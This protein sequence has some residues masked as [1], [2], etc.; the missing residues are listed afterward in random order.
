MSLYLSEA[1]AAAL[2]GTKAA[3][4]SKYGAK[5]AIVDGIRFDSQA[6][7]ARYSTLIV[8]QRAGRIH[9]LELQ[10]VFE[11]HALSGA[12]VCRYRGDFA[13]LDVETG[14]RVCEDVKGV[15]TPLYR[16]KAKFVFEEYGVTIREIRA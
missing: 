7:A 12:T 8:L 6:E 13:Y 10:P 14:L 3:K 4:R 5:P 9:E 15:R 1:D 16:L 11:I 2:L